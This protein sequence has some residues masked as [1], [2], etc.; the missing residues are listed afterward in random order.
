MGEMIGGWLL[1]RGFIEW[2]VFRC[3]GL[4]LDILLC[5]VVEVWMNLVKIEIGS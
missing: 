2:G 3:I 4:V 1:G 5:S